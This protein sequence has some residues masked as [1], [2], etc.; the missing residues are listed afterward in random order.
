MERYIS[1]ARFD[2]VENELHG[3]DDFRKSSLALRVQ[4]HREIIPI[5]GF[6]YSQS[7]EYFGR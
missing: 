4:I 5:T 6:A 2:F 1:D 7:I 3:C